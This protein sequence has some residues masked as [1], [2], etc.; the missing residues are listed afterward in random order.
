MTSFREICVYIIFSFWILLV[1]IFFVGF[2]EEW[3]IWEFE[4]YGISETTGLT[5]SELKYELNNFFEYFVDREENISSRFTEKEKNHLADVRELVHLGLRMLVVFT[6]ILVGLLVSFNGFKQTN[7]VIRKAS[8]V[9][10][11]M[12]LVIVIYGFLAFDSLFLNFHLAAF[13]N[14]D[15]MLDPG[16]HLLIKMFPQEIFVDVFKRIVV[17]FVVFSS[18]IYAGSSFLINIAKHLNTK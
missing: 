3:Y 14:L 2:S 1:C 8:L 15:W 17:A 16:V 18:V 11:F 4:K 5:I 6:I 10:F 7:I 13:S 9:S 12:V